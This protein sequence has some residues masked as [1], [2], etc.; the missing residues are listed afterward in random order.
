[1]PKMCCSS[2]LDSVVNKKKVAVQL[3]F[4]GGLLFLGFVQ[5]NIQYPNFVPIELFFLALYF[6]LDGDKS[7]SVVNVTDGFFNGK[8]DKNS[9][10]VGTLFYTSHLLY[11]SLV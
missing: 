9:A 6:S 11:L 1:M 7:H 5:N 4:F 8:S 2:Y 3:L 10:T